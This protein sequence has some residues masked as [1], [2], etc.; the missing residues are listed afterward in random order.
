MRGS[1][2]QRFSPHLWGAGRV[3]AGLPC[4]AVLL[5]RGMI[6]GLGMRSPQRNTDVMSAFAE[7]EAMDCF[8]ACATRRDDPAQSAPVLAP[9]PMRPCLPAGAMG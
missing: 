1:V 7:E 4:C 6:R 3:R 9:A 5:I 2:A 8:C